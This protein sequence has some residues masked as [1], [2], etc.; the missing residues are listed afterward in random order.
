MGW[1]TGLL[2][3]LNGLLKLFGIGAEEARQAK[4]QSTGAELQ[5]GADAEA[6]LEQTKEAIAARN[7]V[8]PDTRGPDGTYRLPDGS[9]DP[10][11]RD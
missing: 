4:D 6:T 1:L 11:E 7:A 2:T 9:R 3:A 10:D 8:V 5:K